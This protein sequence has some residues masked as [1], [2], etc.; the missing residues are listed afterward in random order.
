[1]SLRQTPA[2]KPQVTST[3]QYKYVPISCRCYAFR[4]SNCLLQL[5]KA[6]WWVF[7]CFQLH[8][9]IFGIH[10]ASLPRPSV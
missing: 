2:L 9:N 8:K 1:M 10:L 6:G 4:F 3:S 5:S 7:R